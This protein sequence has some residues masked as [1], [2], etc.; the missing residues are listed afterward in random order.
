M[1]GVGS[2]S[3]MSLAEGNWGQSISRYCFWDRPWGC[4]GQT[5][6]EVFANVYSAQFASRFN[7]GKLVVMVLFIRRPVMSGDL[8]HTTYYVA[9]WVDSGWYISCIT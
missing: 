6:P 5:V 8:L 3:G 1:T 2:F 7:G 9:T 4:A